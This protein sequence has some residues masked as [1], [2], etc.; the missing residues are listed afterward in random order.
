[1]KPLNLFFAIS[2]LINISIAAQDSIQW[3][4]PAV[5]KLANS[6]LPASLEKFNF[7]ESY[8]DFKK[9]DIKHDQDEIVE[10]GFHVVFKKSKAK[11]VQKVVLFF[12]FFGTIEKEEDKDNCN[13]TGMEITFKTKKDCD[14]YLKT[15]GK[16][17]EDDESRWEF[18]LNKDDSCKG[19]QVIRDGD[20]VIRMFAMDGCGGG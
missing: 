15:L 11:G 6:K 7:L 20:N 13:L 9:R 17:T 16:P 2:L 4:D 3:P 1:M 10:D 8:A 14:E 18:L 19:C 12:S 5:V